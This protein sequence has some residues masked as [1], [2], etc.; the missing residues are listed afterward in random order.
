MR[1]RI[2]EKVKESR[3]RRSNQRKRS[4]NQRKRDP[5]EEYW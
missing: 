3:K 2:K 1:R 5:K 4:L